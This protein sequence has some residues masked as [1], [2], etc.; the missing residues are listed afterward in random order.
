[1][2]KLKQSMSNL[3]HFVSTGDEGSI[4][5]GVRWVCSLV[6]DLA[7]GLG[8]AINQAVNR[9]KGDDVDE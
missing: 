5:W 2:K 4:I 3:W 8:N 1:M 9:G 7:K 6:V